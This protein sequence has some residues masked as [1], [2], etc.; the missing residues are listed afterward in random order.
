MRRIHC[1]PAPWHVF[2][3]GC[4]RL[5]L[6]QDEADYARFLALLGHAL[7]K[8]GCQLWAYALMSNHFHLVLYG[9]SDQLTACMRRIDWMYSIYHNKRYGLGGHCFDGPYQAFRQH[10]ILL[11]LWTIAYVFLNPVKGGLCADPEAY[12]WSGYRSFLGLPGSPLEVDQGSLMSKVDVEPKRAWS[13]FN[14]AMSSELRRPP[15]PAFGR[16]TMLEVHLQQFERLL[17][18]AREREGM[19]RGE[20]PVHVA[21]YWARQSGVGTRAIAQALRLT[22]SREV[23]DVVYQLKRRL[24]ADAAL[25]AVL[26][27]P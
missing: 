7:R 9:S 27:P 21:M 19:L 1:D 11:T 25:G 23:S 6:F 12:P 14:A 5:E 20:D 22:S 18:H 16:L 15:K 3:R 8:S 10:S 24:R 13:R 26:T 17:D 4:R 2:A